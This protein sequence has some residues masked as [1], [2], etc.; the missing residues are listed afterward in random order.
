M[1]REAS[2]TSDG[3][4]VRTSDIKHAAEEHYT[5]SVFSKEVIEKEL[6]PIIFTHG[7]G[8]RLTDVDGNTYID[9]TSSIT[10]ASS[11]GYGQ[12]SI[13]D[14]VREQLI[15]LH[16]AGCTIYS[17]DTPIRLAEVLSALTPGRLSTSVLVGSGTEANEVA[18]KLAKLLHQ[19]QGRKPRAYKV[20][21]RWDA[22][23]GSA[24]TPMAASDWLGVRRPVEPG[25][26]GVS[27]IAAPT[28]FRCPL[29]LEYPD[30]GVRC[31]DLLENQI[32]HEGPEL[33]SAFIAEP[34]M[35]ANG[36]Q[37]PPP[38]YFPRIKEIC[39]RYDVL[40]IA[41][42]VITGFGRTGEWFA[43][44][45]WDVEPDILTM[46]KGITGGYIPLG[47]TIVRKDLWDALPGLPDVHTF[48]GHPAAA[49]AALAAIT[50]YDEDGLIVRSRELGEE[51]LGR[52]RVLERLEIVGQVRGIGMWV[53]VD[54]VADA[55]TRAP[56]PDPEIRRIVATARQEG[57]L[58]GLNGSAIELAPALNITREDLDEGLAKVVR[59]I[60]G[61]AERR[62]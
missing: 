32:L 35:Q 7:E 28:C 39:E 56:L 17:A 6:P 52:L 41:D 30:C 40:F 22:Y 57:V 43:V 62:T 36:V 19:S 53:A 20:I 49:A 29:G 46:A 50:R 59:A 11:L 4:S 15:S 55:A 25:V 13:V 37:T 21:S 31:A 27:H 51:L 47:A 3:D 18:F 16:Y 61:F 48:S 2:M 24:G 54:F 23:H 42:E 26:P 8:V 14:A 9:L 44:E 34:V 10:R 60:E 38:E 1:N 33:V 12:T 58:I 45:H 5:W